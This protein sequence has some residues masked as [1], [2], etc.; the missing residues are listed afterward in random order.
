[1]RMKFSI[2]P[3]YR[4]TTLGSFTVE[5]TWC[6]VRK[7]SILYINSFEEIVKQDAENDNWP[8]A[9]LLIQLAVEVFNHEQTR[10]LEIL[11]PR[12]YENVF[13]DAGFIVIARDGAVS[14]FSLEKSSSN[15][16]TQFVIKDG[17]DIEHV[18][19]AAPGLTWE[20]QMKKSPLLPLPE[21][22]ILP[23]LLFLR[24]HP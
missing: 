9:R 10:E 20:E 5:K 3:R 23:P 14:T 11:A 24:I 17:D 8:L 1:A 2:T 19:L 7:Y 16:L 12:A 15:P 21:G 18:A 4:H 22:P 13:N 6:N